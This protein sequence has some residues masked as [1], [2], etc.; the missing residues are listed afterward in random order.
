MHLII[1]PKANVFVLH[2]AQCYES[3]KN[4]IDL[5][6]SSGSQV[7][8]QARNGASMALGWH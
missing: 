3:V 2:N 4:S 7:S 8:E 1:I 5:V 6:I